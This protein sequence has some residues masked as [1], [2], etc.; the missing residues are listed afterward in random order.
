MR[1][2]LAVLFLAGCQ[3]QVFS[4]TLDNTTDTLVPAALEP[5]QPLDTS[6]LQDLLGFWVD[7]SVLAEQGITEGDISLLALRSLTLSSPDPD[8]DLSFLDGIE[9]W[10]T[11][12]TEGDAK[13]FEYAEFQPGQTQLTIPIEAVDLTPWIFDPDFRV[14][15]FLDGVQPEV[16]TTLRAHIEVEVGTSL[17]GIWDQVN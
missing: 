7:P 4:I 3:T 11:S 17:Y 8:T 14:L 9:T 16:A 10:V 2:T 1:T 5:D 15:S 6:Q 12:P 13:L